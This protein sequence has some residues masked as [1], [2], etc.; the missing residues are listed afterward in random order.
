[1]A[2]LF[3]TCI[4]A[5]GQKRIRLVQA[6]ELSYDKMLGD[7][8]RRVKG[9]VQFE[10]EGAYLYCDSALLDEKTNNV[11]CFSR[12]HIK[13]SDTLN[14]YGDML[15]YNGDTRI[16]DITGKV[17]LIDNQTVLTTTH[18][19]FDRN[20]QIAK[21]EV[22]G[23]I[24]NK[25]NKLIS[26]IGHYYTQQKEFFFK[27][28]VVL[29]NPDYVVN[30]D[31]LKYNT[32]SRTAFF[33]GPSTI[34]G[35]K[36]FIY[37]ENGWYDTRNDVSRFS[38]KAYFINGDQLLKGDSLYY[39]RTNG[40]GK[41][42]NNVSITDTVQNI[43]IRGNLGNYYEKSGFATMTDSAYAILIDKNDS[44]FLHS[45]TLKATFD[46]LRTTKAL[47][48]FH[49]AK[50][51]RND[52]Q[53]MCDSLVYT[54]SDSLLTLY[55][56]PVLWSQANQLT[57][58]T[59]CILIKNRQISEL[60]MYNAAFII[61]KDTLKGYN[62]IK[63]RN[64]HG[65]FR[66]ND[67]VK[68]TVEGNAETIYWI[69]EDDGALIGI[70]KAVSGN[71]DIRIKENKVKKI[72]YIGQPKETLFP[73]KDLLEPDLYLRDFKWLEKSRPLK[74]EDIFGKEIGVGN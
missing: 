36:N 59:I 42:F 57:A 55:H 46:S 71:M 67:L 33:C 1:M 23:V 8:V 53:G 41:G 72:T 16:A 27:E 74:K 2:L 56:K 37:C 65:Y 40:I 20:T 10:H 39:D 38:K 17:K 61:S 44:L 34:K 66:N 24:I 5:Q 73:E 52:L 29:T 22:G 58:D 14:L 45:D 49:S 6:D 18:L 68:V 70:N 63:G 25:E 31:T 4:V 47:Y 64:M 3:T 48:S 21:Y 26:R 28:R 9:N 7:E 35:K 54:I 60:L 19:I 12:I 51:F 15:T 62:Q 11:T 30:S 50:F 32:L 13:S 69:R 43:I